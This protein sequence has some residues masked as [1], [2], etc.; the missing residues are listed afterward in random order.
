MNDNYKQKLN[1]LENKIS[2]LRRFLEIDSKINYVN[3]TKKITET[4]DFWNDPDNA[5]ETL[6]Q[7]KQVEN[8]IEKYYNI[9]KSLEDLIVLAE[10]IDETEEDLYEDFEAELNKTEKVLS[11]LEILF[12]LNGENDKCSAILEINAGAGGTDA[13]DWAIILQRMY[14]RYGDQN[15]FKTTL[16]D[17]LLGDTAGIKSCAIEFSGE[18]AFGYLKCEIG[19][20]RLIRISPFNT[21]GKRQTSFASV[22]VYPIIENTDNKIEISPNDLEITTFRSSGAG[23]QNVNKVET[24]VRIKHIPSG[25]IVACQQERSQFQNKEKAIKLLKSRLMKVKLEE[26]QKERESIEGKKMKIEWGSQ[27]RTYTFQP[28]TMVADHRTNYKRTDLQAVL[29]G[30]I[31]DFIRE[32]LIT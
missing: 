14:L 15:N 3:T 4:A 29:D 18:M 7:I 2:N 5:S 6:K 17:E 25:I 12:L 28:Y 32:F 24:A 31:K 21:L 13:Q 16:I 26:E 10:L 23:G 19:V 8:I 22:F 30:D 20:H 9:T 27:I 1:E 11:D